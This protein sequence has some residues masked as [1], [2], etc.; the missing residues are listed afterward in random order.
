MEQEKVLEIASRV[1]HR[2]GTALESAVLQEVSRAVPQDDF[3]NGAT[4]VGFVVWGEMCA[5]SLA[6]ILATHPQV[7]P[8]VFKEAA[9]RTVEY[10]KQTEEQLKNRKTAMYKTRNL[11]YRLL[12][13]QQKQDEGE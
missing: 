7:I 9:R 6:R 2:I 12:A 13:E 3:L 1:M 11:L 4:E 5:E 8:A 10:S